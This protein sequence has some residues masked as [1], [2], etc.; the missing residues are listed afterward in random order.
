MKN[1]LI[2]QKNLQLYLIL[3]LILFSSVV[4]SHNVAQKHEPATL[5]LINI[6]NE[7]PDL[8]QLLIRSLDIAREINPDRNTNPAQSLEDY[9]QYL[10]WSVKAMPWNALQSAEENPS[11][12]E[13]IDQSLNYF[14]WLIDQP[15]TELEG[16]GFYFNSV[17]YYP[18][19]QP[20][21]VSFVRSW[22]DFLSTEESWNT[23]Y[24][25]K[26]RSEELFNLDN[27]WY[28][29]PTNWKTW[30]D[31]FSRALS[32]PVVRPIVAPDDNSIVVSPA[33]S[34][35]QGVW[36]IDV[37]SQINVGI[38]VKSTEF[39]SV[40]LLLGEN[41]NYAETFANGTITHTFLNVQDYHRFHFPV[42]GTVKEVINI[43]AQDALGG[44]A[45]WDA[46]SER[47]YLIITEPGWQSIQTRGLVVIDTYEH[48][49]V[50]V[51]P[52][53]MSQISSVVFE[54]TVVVG[55]EIRKGD[56]L[57][58]F[59]FGGSDII[60]IFE[61]KAGFEITVPVSGNVHEHILMGQEY[62]RFKKNP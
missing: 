18:A 22:G 37:D 15:L 54:D 38:Q 14:Y 59:L 35:P 5:E 17:Q 26:M 13:A 56:P 24:Y 19:L 20:W 53:G 58:R 62:G 41:S 57:G 10:N 32:S 9:F 50:A 28:E 33:D 42:N 29:D 23:E 3:L 4:C 47:Y 51:L 40:P 61:E 36:Q 34:E 49:Y 43:P 12:F 2:F 27:D 21:I 16:K 31:F 52:V 30:N 25:E 45:V 48:G 39:L 6:L 55:A 44:N 1:N 11:I 60:M 46:D 7:N 8:E